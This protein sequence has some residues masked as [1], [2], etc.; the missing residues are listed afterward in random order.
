MPN[1]TTA[2]PDVLARICADT[3]AEVARARP[4]VECE[5]AAPRIAAQAGR[6]ARLRP[7]AEARRRRAAR[8]GLIAEIKKASPS[9]G[10]IR[11]DFDPAGAGRAPIATAAPPACRC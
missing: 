7:G 10:L 5:R 3:L 1:D 9:G 8:Y 11:P 4:S 6:A 2:P